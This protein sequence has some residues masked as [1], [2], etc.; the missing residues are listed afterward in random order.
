MQIAC[1]VFSSVACLP[2]PYSAKLSHKRQ[3]FRININEQKMCFDSLQF[4]SVI[5]TILRRNEQ[6]IIT[7]AFRSLCKV[8]VI[9]AGFQRN[10]SFHGKFSQNTHI[11]N[12]IK[13]R[14]GNA[15]IFHTEMWSDGETD[16]TNSMEQSLS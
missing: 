15:E 1:V 11:Q 7:K 6:A 12:F 9:L 2:V 10:L 8:D 3:D 13:I 14:P 5:F 16:T 4:L